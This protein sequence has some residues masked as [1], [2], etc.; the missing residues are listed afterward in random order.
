VG[1]TKFHKS[2]HFDKD[3][4]VT[5]MVGESKPGIGGERLPCQKMPAPHSSIPA[6]DSFDLP[7]WVAFDKQVLS[8]DGYFQESVTE[9]RSEQYRVRHVK[10]YFYLEDDSIQLVEPRLKNSGLN[11]GTRTATNSRNVAGIVDANRIVFGKRLRGGRVFIRPSVCLSRR[12]VAAATCSWFAAARARAAD[13]D[14]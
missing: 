2:H 5:L 3:E 12:S 7:A 13:T 10:V 11:Q 4:D 6:G 8:F 14:R 1:K 9:S